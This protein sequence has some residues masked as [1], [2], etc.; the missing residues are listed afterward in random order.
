MVRI[1]PIL[2]LILLSACSTTGDPGSSDGNSPETPE[3]R[4]LR[5]ERVA[6]GAPGEGP[7]RPRVVLAPSAEVLSRELGAEI[8]GSGEG[9][10]LV[11]YR[12]EQPTGGYSVGVAGA[13]IEGNRVTVRVSLEGPPSDALVTQALTY[14][15]EISVLHGVAPEGKSFSFVDGGGET[16]DWPVRRV[17]G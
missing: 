8:R 9:T 14:P 5:V 11:A 4:D 6:A 13:K 2:F 3:P 7:R 12:G 15:Y 17:E 16:L 10:Y 1:G